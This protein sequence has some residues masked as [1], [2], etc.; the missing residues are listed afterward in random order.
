MAS[1]YT[2]TDAEIA[3]VEFCRGRYLWADI[4]ASNLEGNTLTLDNMT[5]HEMGEAI[6][7]EGI[8]LLDDRCGLYK[9]LIY[10]EPV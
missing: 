2:L 6:E 4:V 8:P 5:Q 7:E 9:F 1:K 10:L 3:A